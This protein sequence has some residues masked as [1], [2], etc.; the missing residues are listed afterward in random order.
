MSMTLSRCSSPSIVSQGAG[1][2]RAPFSRIEA[3]LNSVSTVSVDLPPP[4][5]P[6]TQVKVPSGKLAVTFRRL[7]PVAPR[8]IS[9]L[10]LPLRRS[11]GIGIARSPVRYWPVIEAGAAAMSAGRA[12][13]DDLAAVHAGA[14]A[15]VDDVVGLA[16]RLL[17][18]LDDDH[19]VAGVAQVL[20]RGQQ[21]VVVALVQPDRRLVEHVEHAGQPAADLARQPD[22][23]ALAARERA[24]VARQRQVV[25]PD[26][27]QEPEPL[28]DLLQDRPGDLVPLRGQA[29]RHRLDPGQRL[30]DRHPHHLADVQPGDLHRQRL[31]L[32]PEAAAGAARPVVLVALHLLARPG[33]VGLAVAPLHVRD[34][35]LE[36]PADLVDPAALVVAEADLLALRA[37]EQHLLR[38]LRQVAPLRS[39]C[40][41]RSAWPAPR[42]SGDSRATAPWP[43]ARSRR[44]AAAGPRRARSA[45]GRRTARPRARRRPGRRRTGALN[46]N[47]RGSISG[48]VKPETGQAKFSEKVIRCG[49]S[50][51]RFSAAARSRGWRCRRRGRARC[52]GESASRVSSPSRTTMRST[53]TSMLWRY[54]LSSSGGRVE[55]VELAVDL[56]PLE[57]LLQQVLE[58]LAVLALAV[59]HDRR[60]QVGARALGQRHG[61]VDHLADLLRL[62]RQ[63]GGRA[64]RACRRGRTAAAGSRRSR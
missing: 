41:S 44:A 19:G 4:E 50:P 54:F 11:R 6:V 12:V 17:V 23:L 55:V 2:C 64:S 34:H 10:P 27:D 22:A 36:R 20:Q 49:S 38:P 1:V 31:G 26:V 63:P 3:V 39:T 59:A 35:A 60:Q 62:D 40:R 42:S 28:A 16:D 18:V 9:F 58:L 61:D 43:T 30:A 57:A 21:P 25:E 53:T 24:G 7:L 5:T 14:G 32:Q 46:E 52:A 47:S 45:A 13:G 8:T 37:V 51:P 56:D 33:A 29:R 48:M 15:D